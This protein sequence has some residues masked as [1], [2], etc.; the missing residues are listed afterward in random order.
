MA[1]R[2]HD[3]VSTLGTKQVADFDQLVIIGLA[4]RLALHLQS[5][6]SVPY[7]LLKQI[8]LHL[9]H[10]PPTVLPAVVNCLA[11][12]EYLR[13]DKQGQTIRAVVPTVPFFEDLFGDMGAYAGNLQMSEPEQITLAMI[14]R[15]AKS[16]TDRSVYFDMGA[17]KKLV[18]RMLDVGSQ[19]GYVIEKRS[20]GKDILLSPVYF[21]ENYE[22]FADLTAA[23]GG[24]VVSGAIEK[25]SRNQGWPLNLISK[26]SAVGDEHLSQD[27]LTVIKAIATEGFTSPP[28]IKTTHSGQNFFLFTP[29]P[30]LTTITPSKRHVFEAAMALVSAVRQGQLLPEEYAI[31][32]PVALLSALLDRKRLRANTE[33]FEQYKC[34]ATLRVGRL[35][36]A[37]GSWFN[38]ELI[39]NPDNLEAVKMA[40]QLV[41][42]EQVSHAPDPEIL[43]AFHKG[44]EFTDSLLGRRLLA[45][46]EILNIDPGMQDEIDNYLL[47]I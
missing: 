1:V 41:R 38:F 46:Q 47:Q 2:C 31:R 6:S 25:L 22:A 11:D 21:P 10:I 4:V 5:A 9:L 3:V 24:G 30:G 23:K 13:V 19:G 33:A 36:P 14:D 45:E 37:G 42:G 17:E 18:Q 29:K 7:D 26:N 40:I 28:S 44:Q 43:M 34:L 8:A 15:L 16:P 27:E 39:E 12:A 20:R 32:N 35:K